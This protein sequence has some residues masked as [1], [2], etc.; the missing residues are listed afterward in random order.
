MIG[1]FPLEDLGA[2]FQQ[3]FGIELE[4]LNHDIHFD[5]VGLLVSTAGL[6]L[7]GGITINEHTSSTGLISFS[8][9]GVAIQGQLGDIRFE[10]LTIREASFDVFI[11][12]KSVERSKARSSRCALKG[13]VSYEQLLVQVAVDLDKSAD[14]HILWTVFGQLDGYIS[15]SALVPGLKDSFLDISLSQLALIAS[16]RDAPSGRLAPPYPERKGFQICAVIDRIPQLEQLLGGSLQGTVFRLGIDLGSKSVELGLTLPSARTITFSPTVRTGPVELAIQVGTTPADIAIRIGAQL[17]ITL[18]TQPQDLKLAMAIEA[19]ALGVRAFGQMTSD[20]RDP[21]GVGEEVLVRNCTV[22]IGILYATFLETGPSE[23][24]LGGEV[25]IG[26]KVFKGM[27]KISQDPKDELFVLDIVDLGLDD[28]LAFASI[29]SGVALPQVGDV[30]HINRVVMY[31]STGVT[32]GLVYYPMG[33]SAKGVMTVFDKPASIDMV[34]DSG[35]KIVGTV[36]RFQLGP[37]L[38]RGAASATMDPILKVELLPAIQSILIDGEVDI[39]NTST[40]FHLAADLLP[41]PKLQLLIQLRLSDAL[42]VHLEVVLD[43]AANLKTLNLD[44]LANIDLNVYALVEQHIVRSVVDMLSEQITTARKVQEEGYE[45][46]K[47]QLRAAQDQW[48]ASIDSAAAE[49]AV[50]RQ[51][52]EAKKA[53]VEGSLVLA[54]AALESTRIELQGKLDVAITSYNAALQSAKDNLEQAQQDAAAAEA[55][56]QRQV[57]QAEVDGNARIL[58]A[59]ADLDA[60]SARMRSEFGDADRSLED[61]KRQVDEAQRRVDDLQAQIDDLDR[62][63][64]HAGCMDKIQLNFQQKGLQTA[65]LGATGALVSANGVLSVAQMTVNGPG[66]Q[67]AK[68]SMDLAAGTL[69]GAKDSKTFALEKA[70]G[71]L[72]LVKEQQAARVA[73]ARSALDMAR[74]DGQERVLRDA[75]QAAFDAGMAGAQQAVDSA[76]SAVGALDI[77]IEK[78]A[79]DTATNTLKLAQDNTNAVNLARHALDVVHAAEDVELDIVKWVG[80]H[81][82][83]LVDIN[84]MEFSGTL[85]C[86]TSKDAR[87][88]LVAVEAVIMGQKDSLSVEWKPESDLVGFVKDLFGTIWDRLHQLGPA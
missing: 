41:V 26:T 43:G 25:T 86:L 10:D 54:K 35:V 42:F 4:A 32:L 78:G 76:R 82:G 64:E 49:V 88:L 59:Q 65:K 53:T 87:P 71:S 37:L 39:W 17:S 73:D 9:D 63:I 74:D 52:W 36:E 84:T 31:F 12:C 30:L 55:E 2:L 29:V 1:D 58:S 47:G 62:Q 60:A 27:M 13:A 80:S 69:Q 7:Y 23:I 72:E 67:A 66:Y 79:F 15:T 56:A 22:D 16:I 44:A 68:G 46:I 50:A 81:A 75:A 85:Q 77:C 51:A 19:G 48:K 8:S 24:G 14:G 3:L 38:V 20:W 34:V 18:P 5:S 11:A 33:V 6:T 45:Q 21:C 70:N 40:S 61:A 28:L 57:A 83:L